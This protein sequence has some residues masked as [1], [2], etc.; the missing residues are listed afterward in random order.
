VVLHEAR[1][2][3][4]RPVARS[5][6]GERP[7]PSPPDLAEGAHAEAVR[8]SGTHAQNLGGGGMKIQEGCSV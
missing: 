8:A 1:A 5:P 2:Y 6:P 4:S 7:P 3:T